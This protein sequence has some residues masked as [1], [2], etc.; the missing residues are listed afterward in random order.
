MRDSG[1]ELEL[2]RVAVGDHILL[3]GDNMDLA[4]AHHVRQKLEDEGIAL[5]SWQMAALTHGAA[6]GQRKAARRSR[7]GH[8]ADRGAQARQQLVG[9]AVRTEVSRDALSELVLEGF[10]PQVAADARPAARAR[11]GL[12]QIGLPYASDPAIT[13]HLA[14]LSRKHE[15]KPS[16]LLFN[17]G[18]MRSEL[19]RQRLRSTLRRV[20]QEPRQGGART[21][22][23][24]DL[25]LAVAR[26]ARI[27]AVPAT[28]TASA[29]AAVRR[30][31]ITSASR[32]RY[33]RCLGSSRRSA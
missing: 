25:D 24:G 22:S 9:G 5:D 13:K 15:L 11:V 26:G 1:G 33:R 6:H 20:D 18:V 32:R 12:T 10:F 23:G 28:V 30:R 17:G 16:A 3:G 31:R 7:S 19:L 4:L 2:V 8:G 14:E 29:S 21:L 27:T